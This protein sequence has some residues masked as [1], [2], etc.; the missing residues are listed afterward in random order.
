LEGQI[1]LVKKKQAAIRLLSGDNRSKAWS[2]RQQIEE[3]DLSRATSREIVRFNALC[4]KVAK[5]YVADLRDP[6]N[7]TS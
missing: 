5:F 2:I 3:I 7:T 4:S 1:D 6:A